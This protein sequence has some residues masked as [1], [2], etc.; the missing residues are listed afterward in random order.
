MKSKARLSAL[1]KVSRDCAGP[2]GHLQTREE[3]C[4]LEEGVSCFYVDC[5]I[6]LVIEFQGGRG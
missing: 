6:K 5:F 4:G 3:G 1:R 2:M